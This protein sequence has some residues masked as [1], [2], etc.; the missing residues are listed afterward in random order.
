GVDVN[1]VGQHDITPLWWAAWTDNY[2][3]FAALLDKGANPNRQRAEGYPI[4]HLVANAKD[5]RLLEAALKHGGDPN[6][7]DSRSGET[8]LFPAIVLGRKTQIGL[9]LA[10]GADVNAQMPI[11]RQTLAMTAIGA[12]GDYE[13]V[14]QL[15]QKGADPK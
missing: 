3:G 11:S 15:L 12:Q 2:D 14:Y 4:M 6:L 13:I 9:L 1:V 10:A 5:A 7:R 8:P